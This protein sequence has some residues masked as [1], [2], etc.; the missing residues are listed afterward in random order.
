MHPKS[1]VS[2]F[3]GALHLN[4]GALFFNNVMIYHRS[5]NQKQFI[6]RIEVEMLEYKCEHQVLYQSYKGRNYYPQQLLSY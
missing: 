5:I 4:L 3:W 2:N 6:L 1:F